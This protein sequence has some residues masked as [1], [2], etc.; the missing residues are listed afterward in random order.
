MVFASTRLL[1]AIQVAEQLTPGEKAKLVRRLLS[2]YESFA[3]K[4]T[5]TDSS[6]HQQSIDPSIAANVL[7]TLA[8]NIEMNHG[9]A[10]ESTVDQC[11]SSLQWSETNSL[12]LSQAEA[13]D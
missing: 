1:E 3:C 11:S 4:D 8:Q 6:S 13:F 2:D 10:S 12:G 5:V 7:R 9:S